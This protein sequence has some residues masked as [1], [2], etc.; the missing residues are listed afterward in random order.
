MIAGWSKLQFPLGPDSLGKGAFTLAPPSITSSSSSKEQK[1][2]VCRSY[3]DRGGLE[4]HNESFFFPDVKASLVENLVGA[5]I[6]ATE[7]L[8]VHPSGASAAFKGLLG[9]EA[10]SQD[11]VLVLATG[12]SH[13]L[14][15]CEPLQLLSPERLSYGSSAH[16]QFSSLHGRVFSSSNG[17]LRLA[18]NAH[19]HHSVQTSS[20]LRSGGASHG[21]RDLSVNIERSADHG[22]S[23]HRNQPATSE[24]DL[25]LQ[26]ARF[27]DF[28]SRTEPDGWKNSRQAS[29]SSDGLMKTVVPL[30]STQAKDVSDRESLI[31]HAEAGKP[32]SFAEVTTLSRQN[33]LFWGGIVLS[34]LLTGALFVTC[35]STFPLGKQ[36]RR[37]SI[38]RRILKSQWYGNPGSQS[39]DDKNFQMRISE[40]PKY[41]MLE[42]DGDKKLLRVPSDSNGSSAAFVKR[43][44]HLPGATNAAQGQ[45]IRQTIHGT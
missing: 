32:W 16:A 27:K 20:A 34:M 45:P 8:D 14:P 24:E 13:A 18:S 43:G 6:N 33:S 10:A 29:A 21:H 41:P 25:L 2:C 28:K 37:P 1:L 12:P 38:K 39:W 9:F 31:A 3:G 42:V 15:H 40:F 4:P 5:L 44:S 19:A 36:L 26:E 30:R 17:S 22:H 35:R 7:I 11:H 23:H